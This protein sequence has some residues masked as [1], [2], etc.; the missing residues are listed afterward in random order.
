VAT[1]K[2]V[3]CD[4]SQ[5]YDMPG[6]TRDGDVHVGDRMKAAWFKDPDGNTPREATM[7]GKAIG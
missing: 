6:M 5:H 1:R 7:A 3:A 2:D 4:P